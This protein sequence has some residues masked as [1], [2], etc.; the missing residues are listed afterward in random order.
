[1]EGKRKRQRESRKARKDRVD[2]LLL[3]FSPQRTRTKAAKLDSTLIITE[4]RISGYLILSV[5]ITSKSAVIS[6][7]SFVFLRVLCGENDLDTM[8]I[9]K[10]DS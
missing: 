3:A 7:K 9:L 8:F 6:V 10:E 1:M 2:R 5:H 4:R